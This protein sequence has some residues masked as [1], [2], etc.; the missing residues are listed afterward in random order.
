MGKDKSKFEKGQKV[1]FRDVSPR[2]T[3]YLN[4]PG[5]IE[6]THNKYNNDEYFV[7]LSGSTDFSTDHGSLILCEG[8]ELKKRCEHVSCS[9]ESGFQVS[10]ACHIEAKI[11]S[12]YCDD[13]QQ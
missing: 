5:T 11:G 7:K 4:S 6:S 9:E 3:P 13:H 2:N 10:T 8:K 1:V 12:I